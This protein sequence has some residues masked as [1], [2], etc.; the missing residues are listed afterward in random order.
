MNSSPAPA[1]NLPRVMTTPVAYSVPSH[2]ATMNPK[3]TSTLW[4]ISIGCEKAQPIV[5]NCRVSV[6]GVRAAAD[7]SREVGFG[8]TKGVALNGNGTMVTERPFTGGAI[9]FRRATAPLTPKPMENAKTVVL[10]RHGLSSWNEEGRVQG[11]SDK[12]VLSDVG[13]LQAIRVRDS[14]SQL[15]FDRCFASPITRAKT[16]AELIWEG[17]EK[18]LVY[19]DTLREANLHF[20]E[21]MLNSEAREQY[22]ELFRSWREDPLNFNVN[23]VYPVVEL[24]A[25]AK[26]A[27][28]EILSAP[29][30]RLLVVTH[31]SILRAML[32]TA[33]GLGP[34][35]FRGVDVHN[36]GVSTF[37]VN[38]RGEPM[39]AS[40][41]RTA[42][43]H[44]DG[45][46]Y[47][48]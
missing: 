21:G 48:D 43:L 9:D 2:V 20:L 10:V 31:K 38:T 44:V 33:L 19:L 25:K 5:S 1:Q 6:T 35:R 26:L 39:L 28:E 40:L 46:H 42:H 14:L 22:P 47:L 36:A 4:G 27:W 45:V 7:G 17:R 12:S 32:C 37:T 18:P 13:K 23:G 41:N 11:S 3:F 34:D 16:S 29:G 30:E 24:W 8:T 15:D